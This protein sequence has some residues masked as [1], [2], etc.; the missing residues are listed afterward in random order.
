MQSLRGYIFII[1]ML[2]P[3][4]SHAAFGDVSYKYEPTTVSTLP[5][6]TAA[7]PTITLNC[8]IGQQLTTFSLYTRSSSGSRTLTLLVD[9][10]T[11]SAQNTNTTPAWVQWTGINKPCLDGTL[12]IRFVPSAV[13][14]YIY[15][16]QP[17]DYGD[18]ALF[19]DIIGGG[20]RLITSRQ[21]YTLP[22]T[23]GTGSATSSAVATTT[24]I[25]YND[26]LI[27]FTLLFVI[28]Y[29]VLF[30]IIFLLKPFYAR[31]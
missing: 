11:T 7:H 2:F 14:F 15:Y 23:S 25:S 28:V 9:S 12:D 27:N 3:F 4:A 30:G 1:L 21:T 19:S 13:N 22:L 8:V 17:N 31:K 20:N 6:A 29:M 24:V 26:Q 18:Y 16:N 5:N 10:A